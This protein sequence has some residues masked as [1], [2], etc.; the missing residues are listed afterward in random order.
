MLFCITELIVT[1]KA[2]VVHYMVFICIEKCADY[3]VCFSNISEGCCSE[4]IRVGIT[5][6]RI[7]YVGGAHRI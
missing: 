5:L 6:E 4:N 2:L 1:G 7:R 3:F